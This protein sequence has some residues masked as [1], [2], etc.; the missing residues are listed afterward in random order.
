MIKRMNFIEINENDR[1]RERIRLSYSISEICQSSFIKEQ[2]MC[3]DIKLLHVIEIIIRQLIRIIL[4]STENPMI[5]RIF[6]L[7]LILL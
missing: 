3:V 6:Y 1:K 4:I 7:L 2:S 5:T